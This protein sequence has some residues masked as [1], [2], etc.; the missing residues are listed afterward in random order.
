MYPSWRGR[1]QAPSRVARVGAVE[2]AGGLVDGGILP[3]R[4]IARLPSR[5]GVGPALRL[6]AG[7]PKREVHGRL[8][9]GRA[10]RDRKPCPTQGGPDRPQPARI[11]DVSESEAR[12]SESCESVAHIAIGVRNAGNGAGFGKPLQFG[13]GVSIIGGW[14]DVGHEGADALIDLAAMIGIDQHLLA[15]GAGPA[16][17]CREREKNHQRMG[18]ALAGETSPFCARSITSSQLWADP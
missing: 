5:C 4:G 12:W 16:E 1:T 18:R 15:G 8:R 3:G 14:V 9:R 10:G 7:D 6:G 13:D 11:G 17:I 2:V